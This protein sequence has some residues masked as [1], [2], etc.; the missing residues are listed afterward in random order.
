MVPA[1]QRLRSAVVE[2]RITLPPDRRLAEHAAKAVQRHGR[3]GW[4]LDR[5]SRSPDDAIDGLIAL[6]MALERAENRPAPVRLLGW[7]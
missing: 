5:A 1:S 7:L 4:R 3:R 2:G 6:C